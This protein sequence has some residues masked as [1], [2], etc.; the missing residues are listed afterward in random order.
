MSKKKAIFLDR[1][2]VIN[3]EVNYLSDPDDFKLIDGT[4]EALFLL[5]Q[6]GYLLIVVTNQAGIARGFFTEDRLKEIHDKMRSVLMESGIIL[7]DVYYCPHHPDFTGKCSC[8]KPNPGMII[9]A[10]KNYDLNLKES[11]MVGDTLNDIKTGKNAGC[12]TVL[13]LTGYGKK[14]QKKIGD[15]KPDFIHDDLLDFA[16]NIK[17]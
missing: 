5:K 14:E 9:R 2:G 6:K 16:K 15:V 12:K 1:D 7:D 8:R 11:F 13:V 17:F 3:I 4:I 10:Q